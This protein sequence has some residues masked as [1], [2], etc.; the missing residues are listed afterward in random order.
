MIK[1]NIFSHLFVRFKVF[2]Y[3]KWDE[4]HCS[5]HPIFLLDNKKFK[6]KS[7]INLYSYDQRPGPGAGSGLGPT[8][9]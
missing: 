2:I 6:R 7:I 8:T 3:Q 4:L 1:D 9:G 5:V